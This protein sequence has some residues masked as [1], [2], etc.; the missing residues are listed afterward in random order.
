M[1][2]IAI[3]LNLPQE[4]VERAQTA[5]LLTEEQVERWLTEKLTHQEKHYELDTLLEAITPDNR[6]GEVDTGEATGNEI[7]K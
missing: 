2:R 5:G 1:D 3:T 4:L 6:H 7:V